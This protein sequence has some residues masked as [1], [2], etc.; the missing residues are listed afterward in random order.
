M[1]PSKLRPVKREKG[2]GCHPQRLDTHTHTHTWTRDTDS[3]KRRVTYV[4]WLTTAHVQIL[5]ECR[6]AR[7]LPQHWP[8]RWFHLFSIDFHEHR[9]G[10]DTKRWACAHWSTSITSLPKTH[11]TQT[12]SSAVWSQMLRQ[13][14]FR[15]SCLIY[16]SNRLDA[17]VK[18]SQLHVLENHLWLAL[19]LIV[20]S[21]EIRW[22][23]NVRSG[24]DLIFQWRT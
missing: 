5:M 17:A 10:S 3:D 16:C 20:C 9:P 15:V 13:V 11:K 18:V 12:C 1:Y 23:T 19:R 21:K 7:I 14:Y 6:T 24:F 8:A 2:A 4:S 22:E